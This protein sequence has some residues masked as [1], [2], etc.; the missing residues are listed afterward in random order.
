MRR[1]CG[2]RPGSAGQEE[3]QEGQEEGQEEEG[4]HGESESPRTPAV[5]GS[6][7]QDHLYPPP[8]PF[9]PP[10]SSLPA[11]THPIP[12]HPNHP[13]VVPTSRPTT[14]HQLPNRQ[15]QADRSIESLFAELV[16]NG[17]LQQCPHVHVRDYLGSSSYM[18]AT[19][20]KANIIP[21]P[22]M[23]Q[24][25]GATE[26]VAA[27]GGRWAYVCCPQGSSERVSGLLPSP[28]DGNADFPR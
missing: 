24:A 7:L 5:N 23:A 11:T 22:S 3:G 28:M 12:A 25:R 26:R 2:G 27:L 4:P 1:D 16:S 9:P 19:L 18:A 10:L 8:R 14:N 13:T 6:S 15:P 21:D 20:E 17:I